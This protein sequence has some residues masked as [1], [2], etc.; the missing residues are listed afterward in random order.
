MLVARRRASWELP[1]RPAMEPDN[2]VAP[3]TRPINSPLMFFLWRQKKGPRYGRR[4]GDSHANRSCTDRE[5][6]FEA[7]KWSRK[8]SSSGCL[9]LIQ[10]RLTGLALNQLY[11][12]NTLLSAA[13]CP[14]DVH[15]LLLLCCIWRNLNIRHKIRLFGITHTVI[16]PHTAA[17]GWRQRH[18]GYL[19]MWTLP[20]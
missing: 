6:T 13:N 3:L 19:K 12:R 14:V 2:T 9:W 20:A 10:A 15:N 17:L 4:G 7:Q 16:Y 11:R 5:A 1:S 18:V 8:R